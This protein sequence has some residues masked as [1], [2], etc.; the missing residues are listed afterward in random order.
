MIMLNFNNLIVHNITKYY[1]PCKSYLYIHMYVSN[2]H[3]NK[4]IN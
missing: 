1:Q 2:S 4:I 3:L